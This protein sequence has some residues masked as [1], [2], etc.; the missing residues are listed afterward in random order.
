MFPLWK[1]VIFFRT[2]IYVETSCIYESQHYN[3]I[4][5]MGYQLYGVPKLVLTTVI[6]LISTKQM[7]QS[8][9]SNHKVYSLHDLIRR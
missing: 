1:S 9:L 7:L 6:S 5:T 8:N 4:V 2:T 3:V